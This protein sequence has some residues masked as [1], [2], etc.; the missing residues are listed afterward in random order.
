MDLKQLDS[1]DTD[2]AAEV[3]KLQK[4][5]KSRGYYQGPEDGK[6]GGG[7]TD[8]AK[9]L[10][11]ELREDAERSLK[12]EEA[13]TEGIKAT[14]DPTAR[15]TKMATE[16]GPWA[17]GAGIGLSA[18]LMGGKKANAQ[19]LAQKEAGSRLAKALDVHPEAAKDSLTRMDKARRFRGGAQFMGPAGFFGAGALTSELVAP[20]FKDD[21]ETQKYINLAATTENAAGTTMAAKQLLD[22]AFRGDP[23]DPEDRA[24][25]NAR[26]MPP[27]TLAKA[28]EADATPAP[29]LP[30]PSASPAPAASQAPARHSL[31]LSGAVSAA[32]RSPGTSKQGNYS[33]LAKSLTEQNLPAVA[34]A[35]NLPKDATKRSVL[36][37]ARELV[38]TRGVSSYL[39]PVAAG[40]VAY[41]AMRSPSQAEDG[42]TVEGASIPEAAAVGAGAAGATAGGMYGAGKLAQALAPTM[43]GRVAARAFP[44]AA[45]GLA[46]YDTFNAIDSL[47][48]LSPPQDTAEYSTMGA[49]MPQEASPQTEG[50]DPYG[51]AIGS[52]IRRMQATGASPEQIAS[53]LNQAIR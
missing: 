10:R 51:G 35:L 3:K 22:L 40:A 12:T 24:R 45:A 25:I 37:R 27:S 31:R 41:D 34:E 18:A 23:I 2:N 21:P 14:N 32:G 9:K 16:F 4:F 44:P 20:R 49:F 53:F 8:A 1:I 48:H 11:A 17:G 6:W 46:A 33:L 5:L 38:N 50:G 47:A 19:D 52:R 39:V 36:Q 43:L 30:S 7:T 28:L 29:A 26:T 42:S 13:K 15:L